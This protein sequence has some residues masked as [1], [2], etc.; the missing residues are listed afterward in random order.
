MAAREGTEVLLIEP[1]R[2]VGGLST[3]G[4]N[5]A[6]TEHMLKWTFGGFAQES[7]GRLGAHY[8]ADATEMEAPRE[9]KSARPVY[10]L[11]SGVAEEIYLQ[12]L[13]EAGDRFHA[14]Q[15]WRV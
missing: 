11:E 4:I 3:S 14:R 6:E 12:L 5:T 13:R 7:Y 9:D 2:H 1:T 10:Q 15:A 8:G